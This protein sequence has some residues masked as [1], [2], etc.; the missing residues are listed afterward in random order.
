MPAVIVTAMQPCHTP[1]QC[2]TFPG[3]YVMPTT[4]VPAATVSNAVAV[5]FQKRWLAIP[6]SCRGSSAGVAL[7]KS[8]STSQVLQQA[9]SDASAGVHS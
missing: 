8:P 2:L 6:N 1:L 4:H 9:L 5:L 3:P 7:S